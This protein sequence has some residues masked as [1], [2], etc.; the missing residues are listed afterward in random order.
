MRGHI[1]PGFESLAG[2]TEGQRGKLPRREESGSIH[3]IISLELPS[4]LSGPVYND[5]IGAALVLL[6]PND[7]EEI[8][9]LNY[10]PGLLQTLAYRGLGW[11]LIKVDETAREGP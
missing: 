3:V 8:G 1:A 2:G 6:P 10:Q 9:N 11:G 7:V 5:D 4:Y